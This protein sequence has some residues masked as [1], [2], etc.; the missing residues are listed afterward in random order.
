MLKI[1]NNGKTLNLTNFFYA[2][3]ISKKTRRRNF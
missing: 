2:F 3:D 1:L